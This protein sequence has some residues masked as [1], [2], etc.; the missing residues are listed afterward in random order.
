MNDTDT[1]Y[2]YGETYVYELH[3]A[4]NDDGSTYDTVTCPNCGREVSMAYDSCPYCGF[5]L[6]D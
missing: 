4:Y 6:W 3:D 2:T 1:Q 5:G